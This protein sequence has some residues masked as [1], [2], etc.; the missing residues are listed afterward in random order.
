M[1]FG[2]FPTDVVCRVKL[3]GAADVLKNLIPIAMIADGQI[4]VAVAIPITPGDVGRQ[5]FIRRKP[6]DALCRIELQGA[7]DILIDLIGK[8]LIEKAVVAII[9]H[10][11]I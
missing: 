2:R 4:Q 6:A 5:A 11:Q 10:G 8:D 7:A 1:G 3:Q 9:A